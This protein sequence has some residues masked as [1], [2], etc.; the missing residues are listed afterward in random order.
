MKSLKYNYVVNIVLS[1]YDSIDHFKKVIQSLYDQ[2][3]TRFSI[4]ILFNGF[5]PVADIGCSVREFD[6]EVL[7]SESR[8]K[9]FEAL[10][11]LIQNAADSDVFIRVDPDDVCAPSR[12]GRIIKYFEKRVSKKTVFY[13]GCYNVSPMGNAT[14]RVIVDANKHFS[15]GYLSN[16]I[17]HST[18]AYLADEIQ[19]VGGY[20]NFAKAQDL[21]LWIKCFKSGFRF[22]FSEE[23]LVY[24]QQP[25]NVKKTRGLPYFSSEFRIYLYALENEFVGISRF[26]LVTIF[27]FTKR[28]LIQFTPNFIYKL[29]FR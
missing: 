6:I 25:L 19:N 22:D 21:G 28:A 14:Q 16:P 8:L 3:D 1:E 29:I 7:R 20:P 23:P 15:K 24:F 26:L 5:E 17:V 18:T 13:S 4:K 11:Y 12:V 27:Q 2:A 9:F 10:N